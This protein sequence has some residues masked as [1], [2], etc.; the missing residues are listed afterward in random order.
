M[1]RSL[2]GLFFSLIITSVVAQENISV[3]I[4]TGKVIDSSSKDPVAYT[5][6][7]LEG[8]FFGTASDSEG[9]FVLKVPGEFQDK[10]IFFSAVGYKNRVFPV[11][12]LFGKDF[13]LIQLEGQT[14]SIEDIDIN[15]ESKVLVRIL[16][17]AS[18]NVSKNFMT[19]PATLICT[20]E[21]EKKKDSLILSRKATIRIDDQTGYGYPSI[22]DAYKKRNYQFLTVQKNFES[23]S[24]WDGST[25]MDEILGLDFARSLSSVLN[26]GILSTFRLSREGE[27]VLN[28]GA[29]WVIGFSQLSPTLS[30]TGDFYASS[31]NGKIYIN[32][33]NYGVQKI[34]AWVQA[35]RQNIIGRGLAI[36]HNTKR[37]YT[38][39]AYD[40]SVTYNSKGVEFISLN[41]NYK[42]RGIQVK[43]HTQLIVNEIKP[44]AEKPVTSRDYF[45]GE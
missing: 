25:N 13:N 32:K 45:E 43:E 1:M 40:F 11:A 16:R 5:N 20:Y 44:I 34:E 12:D 27:T 33:N 23:Y 17:T 26:P 22:T 41:K 42:E 21:N 14:Y 3:K 36:G 30:G 24:L 10:Q 18:E 31:F 6:I 9:N 29:V 39:V 4:I 15:A 2:I 7:G 19:Q 37:Y 35:P 8:T 28:K 38:D